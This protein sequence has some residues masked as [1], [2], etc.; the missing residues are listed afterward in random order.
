[1]LRVDVQTYKHAHTHNQPPSSSFA[2]TQKIDRD[3]LAE[4]V[5][6][7]LDS[8]LYKC[9]SIYRCVYMSIK[10]SKRFRQASSMRK[11]GP[12]RNPP[13]NKPPIKFMRV[14]KRKWNFTMERMMRSEHDCQR[15][16][17]NGAKGNARSKKRKNTSECVCAAELGQLAVIL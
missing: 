15:E 16:R 4:T 13:H 6:I 12:I 14:W 17:E 11:N 3:M 7:R 5:G 1:M 2:S 8:I 9:T 10:I